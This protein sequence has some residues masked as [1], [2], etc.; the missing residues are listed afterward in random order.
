MVG[1]Q[2]ASD[3]EVNLGGAIAAGALAGAVGAAIAAGVLIA[4]DTTLL[5]TLGGDAL[6]VLLMPGAVF[7]ALYALL[8]QIPLIAD[9]ATEPRTGLLV[10]V[11]YGLLFWSTTIPGGANPQRTLV[12]S[13]VFGA[14]IGLLYASWPYRAA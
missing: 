1:E 9:L 7:G 3:R 14:V 4:M 12:A 2:T 5:T 10:G 11:G 8:A 13:L 6:G